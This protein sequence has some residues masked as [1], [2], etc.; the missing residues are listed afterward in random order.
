M[1]KLSKL[2]PVHKYADAA[3]YEVVNT[4]IL[5]TRNERTH[6]DVWLPHHRTGAPAMISV[7]L[8]TLG[9][10]AEAAETYLIRKL[11]DG[12][13]VQQAYGDE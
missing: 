11:T 7:G 10:A 2:S 12:L 3:D 5:I 8:R 9:D 1:L 6:W 4:P 13:T